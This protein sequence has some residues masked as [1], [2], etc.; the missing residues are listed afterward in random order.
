MVPMVTATRPPILD[1]KRKQLCDYIRVFDNALSHG[2]CARTIGI[3]EELE[4]FHVRHGHG[5]ERGLDDSGWTELD[6][7]VHADDAFKGY[8]VAQI[9]N[10]LQLYN[11]TLRLTV[12]IP[13]L[14]MYQ[15]LRMKRYVADNGDRFQPH[16]DSLGDKSHRYLVFLW[17]LNDVE[18]GG[19]TLFC[20]LDIRIAA[21]AGR[22]L[23]FPPYWMFQHAGLPPQSGDKYILS[24]YLMFPPTA[25]IARKS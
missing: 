1:S 3:F 14:K 24:T 2:F 23:V 13:D 18:R 22:L 8:F 25:G 6:I 9:R 12:P 4:K 5:V 11:D 21:R 19:E 20:D 15:E 7:S 10:Y 17:Y 16:F